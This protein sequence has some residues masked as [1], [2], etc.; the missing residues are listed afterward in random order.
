M[1][2]DSRYVR[3][4]KCITKSIDGASD[5]NDKRSVLTDVNTHVR[6]GMFLIQ[7]GLDFEKEIYSD[8]FHDYGQNILYE[9]SP[10]K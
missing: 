5:D 2:A 3:T 6:E 8:C 4:H 7:Q 1:K 10:Q 9:I